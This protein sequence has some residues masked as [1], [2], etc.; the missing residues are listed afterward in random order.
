MQLLLRLVY[1]LPVLTIYD[2]HQA[3]ST[4]VVMSPKRSD[5]ILSSYIPY[6][7]LDVLIRDCLHVETDC[8]SVL[9]VRLRELAG[10]SCKR[11]CRN[12]CD[13]LVQLELVQNCCRATMS[14]TRV[15]EL[16]NRS[17]LVFPAASKPNINNLISLLPKR[18][19]GNTT[20]RPR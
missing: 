19:P 6:I 4:G 8:G 10:L 2:E 17:S 5:F 14:I 16:N 3:L 12:R 13:R 18:R 9:M 1:P 15:A 11:T 20:A 7:K